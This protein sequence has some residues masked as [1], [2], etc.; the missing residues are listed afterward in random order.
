MSWCS[1]RPWP[2]AG[3]RPRGRAWAGS[4]SKSGKAAHA[5]VAPENG[6][7][8]IVELAHQILSLQE[9][10]DLAAGTT[11]NVGVIQGG[12]ATNV[13]PAVASAEIDVRV[14][15]KA[16]ASADRIGPSVARARSRPR[17]GS[18]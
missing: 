18:R 14:A 2:T 4:I 6:R 7:S 3:S 5:G 9:L 10:E 15:S 17:L 12:T 16:E 11:I 1:S 8:A 13:V